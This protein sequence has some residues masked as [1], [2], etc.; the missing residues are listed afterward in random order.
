MDGDFRVGSWLVQP[1]L[2]TISLADAKTQLEP[3]VMEVLLCLARH[4]GEVLSKDKLIQ[5]AWPGTF[6]TDDVLKRCISQ[7]RHAFGDDVRDPRFIDTIPKRGYRL[8]ASVEWISPW[9]SAPEKQVLPETDWIVA[10]RLWRMF[11]LLGIT[12]ALAFLIVLSVFGVSGVRTWLRP[13]LDPQIHS[14]AVLPLRN[15]SADPAQEYFSDGMTDALITNLAQVGPLKVISQ[16]SVMRYKKT[17]KTLPEIAR[18]LNVDGIVEGTVQRSGD[19]IRISAQLIHGPSDKH[20]WAR[21]YERELRDTLQLQTELARDIAEGI[22]ANLDKLAG[23]HGNASYKLNLEAY[24]DY[25]KGR[26]LV[27]R[28]GRDDAFKGV[29]LL[30]RSVQRDAN[31][32][33]AYAELSHGYQV[34][35]TENFVPSGDV[36]PK[37]REGAIKALALDENLSLAHSVLGF[38]RGTYEWDWGAE[39]SE[40]ARA[41]QLDP[42]SSSAHRWY[43]I[44]LLVMGRNEEAIRETNTALQLDPFSPENHSTAS[45]V[46]ASLRQY[47]QALREAR[48]AVE[49]DPSFVHGHESLASVL[50][51]KGEFK[52]AFAE[53]LRALSLDG[54]EELA[55]ELENAAKKISSP[56]DPGQKLSQITL[57]YYQK[58]AKSKYVGPLTFVGIYI[59]MGDKDKAFQWL[60]TAAEQRELGLPSLMRSPYCDVLRSDPRFQNLLRRMNLPADFTTNSKASGLTK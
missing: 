50:G 28:S 34:L 20:L 7:L 22:S 23:R 58:K 9:Q 37:V 47:D 39:E 3:K 21:S 49:I 17:Q 6:V 42:N 8:V 14:L 13:K 36:A 32:A 60:N 5:S 12:A 27:R 19:R 57:R 18:E 51:V 30:E 44:H 38:V 25:L 24:D 16:T 4:A 11:G 31:Y 2:N 1:S 48:R 33:P 46:F 26:N 52:E 43:A 41:I 45:Y 40:L 55:T 59:D 29:E 56:G 10:K 35:A 54:D 15:L 53:W